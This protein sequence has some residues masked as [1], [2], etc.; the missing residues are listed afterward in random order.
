MFA[1][2]FSPSTTPPSASTQRTS[3][4]GSRS[5]LT[6]GPPST[7]TASS[8]PTTS[9]TSSSSASKPP[10]PSPHLQNKISF[11]SGEIACR[12]SSCRYGSR[13]YESH[14]RLAWLRSSPLCT[15]VRP[16]QRSVVEES[17]FDL[18]VIE[19]VALRIFLRFRHYFFTSLRPYLRLYSG[20]AFFLSSTFIAT[21][22]TLFPSASARTVTICAAS[23]PFALSLNAPSAI[24][25][26]VPA[27]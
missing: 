2:G 6:P 22:P 23:R 15:R 9:P 26:R 25:T 1:N 24:S 13:L 8:S 3:P 17:L 14:R 11:S 21:S 10:K 7:S 5:L 19:R 4:Y 18:S 16:D 20:S 12:C 27:V